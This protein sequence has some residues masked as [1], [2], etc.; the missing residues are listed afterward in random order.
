MAVALVVT[1]FAAVTDVCRY[2][3]YNNLTIPL[4]LA[5]VAYHGVTGDWIGIS[6]SLV[7]AMLGFGILLIPYAMGLMGAGDVKLLAAVGAW[8]GPAGILVVFV[9]SALLTG[10]Y[11]LG[12]IAYRAKVRDSLLTLQ[13]IWYRF[14]A[15]GRSLGGDDLV[16]ELD[17]VPD[18]RLR[19]IPFGAAVPLG[20]IGAILWFHWF[21]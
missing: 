4:F 14:A 9:V 6:G 10:I 2:R 19:V 15:L 11:A 5:G 18:R 12:L 8:V 21:I 16:E 7:G 3:V 13:L 20:V 1:C 17:T